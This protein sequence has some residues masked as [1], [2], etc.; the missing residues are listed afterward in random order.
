MLKISTLTFS[1]LSM[2]TETCS[3]LTKGTGDALTNSVLYEGGVI[4]VNS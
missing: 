3:L 1:A 4:A 2:F